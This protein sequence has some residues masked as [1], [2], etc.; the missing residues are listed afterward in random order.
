MKFFRKG[1]V[2]RVK[3]M[4]DLLPP[5]SERL[6]CIRRSVSK[7]L[8]LGG[9]RRL[10]TPVLEKLS[11]YTIGSASSLEIHS[12]ET[13]NFIERLSREHLV[14]R[15]DNTVPIVRAAENHNLCCG[16]PERLWY[17]EPMFRRERNQKGR[18]RQ[19]HQIGV[20][21][22]GAPGIEVEAELL[23]LGNKIL[24]EL[25]LH[26][27]ELRLNSIGSCS[28]RTIYEGKLASYLIKH[29]DPIEWGPKR[30][31]SG[32]VR[33]LDSKH[34]S[35]Q[36]V[37]LTS[38][39]LH[40][41]FCEGS[42]NRFYGLQNILKAL[43]ISFSLDPCLVRGLDYY[44]HTVYEWY[45]HKGAPQALGAGGRYDRL[46]NRFSINSTGCGWA[47]GLERIEETNTY[48]APAYVDVYIL[49]SNVQE[50]KCGLAVKR[51]L[52]DFNLVTVLCPHKWS[53]RTRRR[54]MERDG[55]LAVIMKHDGHHALPHAPSLFNLRKIEVLAKFILDELCS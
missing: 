53:K 6:D 21:V 41:F 22:L 25:G 40:S 55:A 52:E 36:E 32:L 10:Q 30:Q 15:P 26:Q 23:S 18:Y 11:L 39:E 16:E 9:F 1:E 2:R 7:A 45:E 35:T 24:K 34:P 37:V 27:A 50:W 48:C 43:N 8:M 42:L 12:R 31:P 51:I 13:F 38:P 19:F 28:D 44:D 4:R 46:L 54:C 5:Q 14:M 20:E 29:L 33:L 17:D 3:G 49:Y 47:L